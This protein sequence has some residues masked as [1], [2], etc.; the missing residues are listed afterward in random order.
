[1]LR[2]MSRLTRSSS[3]SARILPI[4]WDSCSESLTVVL[5]MVDAREREERGKILFVQRGCVEKRL[6]TRWVNAVSAA[7]D[8]GLLYTDIYKG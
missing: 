1:M 8:P 4:N 3:V 5:S 2:A 7:I 6:C